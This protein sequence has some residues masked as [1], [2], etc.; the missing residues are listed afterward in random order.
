MAGGWFWSLLGSDG[1]SQ[2]KVLTNGSVQTGVMPLGYDVQYQI[3]TV[4]GTMAAAL[5]ANSVVFS[6]RN[7]TTS[8]ADQMLHIQRIRLR[9]TTIVA[10]TTPITAGR[11]LEI[12]RG[13]A[14]SAAY[15]GGTAITNATKKVTTGIA[16]QAD[17][18]NG[19]DIRI[20]TTGALTAPATITIDNYPFTAITLTHVGTAGASQDLVAEFSGAND[21]PIEL[22]AGEFLLIRNP[23][24]MDAAGTWQLSVEIDFYQM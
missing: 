15:T 8:T 22:G 5:A 2:A 20:A 10:Y 21:Q 14:A 23:V 6:M 4:T 12:I 1:V 19:G 7:A 24:A 18:A 16:S 17:A 13:S 9:Y 3:S 11:R